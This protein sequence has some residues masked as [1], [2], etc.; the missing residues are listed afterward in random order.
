M[1]EFISRKDGYTVLAGGRYDGLVQELGGQSTPAIGFAAGE[2]RLISLISD[3]DIYKREVDMYIVS[4]ENEY[5]FE[6]MKLANQ[7]REWLN[8][9]TNISSRSFNSQMKYANKINADYVIVLGKDEIENKKCKIKDMKTG[10]E[11]SS[12]LNSDS[13]LDAIFEYEEEIE[14]N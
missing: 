6:A 10:N 4:M 8:I 2:E 3:E 9:Q 5:E 7:L 12:K 14:T 13:I 11:F 1:F